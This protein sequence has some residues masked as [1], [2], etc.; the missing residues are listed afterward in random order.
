MSPGQASNHIAS[1]LI[2]S[3][4]MVACSQ[5]LEAERSGIDLA[6][7]NL[8]L[9]TLDTTRVD[10][11]GCY[12][13]P[14]WVTPNLDRLAR[15]GV[16]FDQA[17][18]VTPITLPSHATILTGLYPFEHGVRDNATFRLPDKIETIAER[19]KQ[20]GYATCAVSGAFVMHS[21]FGLDQG[22]DAYLDVPRRKLNLGV[23]EDQRTA[24]EVVDEALKFLENSEKDKPLFL[25]V[26]LF[27]PHFP[28][29]PPKE[30]ARRALNGR[31]SRSLSSQELERRL[32]H[33][34]VAFMDQEIGRLIQAV[35]KHS[36]QREWLTAAVADHGEGLGDH[37]EDTHAFMLYDTTIRV[38]MILSHDRLAGG[39]VVFEPVSIADLAPTMM[40]LLGIPFEGA[41]GTDLSPRFDGRNQEIQDSLVYYETAHP[42][43]NYN[44]SP[45]FGIVDQGFKLIDG[46]E[47]EL[48]DPIEDKEE[49]KNLAAQD[50][51]K[52]KSLRKAVL[53]LG[54]R[55]R[56]SERLELSREDQIRIR[57]L[58][59]AGS[60]VNARAKNPLFPG[61][62]SEGLRDPREGLRIMKNCTEA[63]T[64]AMK[65]SRTDRMKAVE[66]I[67]KALREDPRNPTFLLHACSI[68]FR[69]NMYKEAMEAASQ[70]LEMLESPSAREVQATCLFNL[71]RIEEA[72][73]LFKVNYELHPH[74]LLSRFKLGAAL[75]R[76][77]KPEESL[78]HLK[79]FL[80]SY[81]ERDELYTN[82]RL[83]KEQAEYMLN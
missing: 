18:S 11:L 9:I 4:V 31:S 8:L 61:R 35:R 48:Y 77:R 29:Q 73:A 25:W 30:F 26:H 14:A 7:S 65:P 46:P 57:G 64:L 44:W 75:L 3:S 76:M 74:D 67:E 63:R 55:I 66:E 54:P 38:P 22:F 78:L 32:Y 36:P 49:L 56:K 50:V 21:S 20:E 19:L 72:V 83:M 15:N 24:V 53:S 41:T 17:R 80:D 40:N 51:D 28:Y 13:G 70:S 45:L 10:A 16:R 27:D 60:T 82:A 6:G 59:Y 34:E 2:L 23:A 5:Q 37:E 71:G 39:K 69:A 81:A 33:G 12:G 62:L 42:F 52:L 58:G 68:Y 1:L 43:Y 79:F 47:P